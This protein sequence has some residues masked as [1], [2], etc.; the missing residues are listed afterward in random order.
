MNDH[1]L[2]SKEL[3]FISHQARE[4]ILDAIYCT[5]HNKGHDLQGNTAESDVSWF[6]YQL[7]A[8]LQRDPLLQ[9][10]EQL[11]PEERAHWERVA[12]AS[13][14]RLPFLMDRISHRMLTTKEAINTLLHAEKSTRKS[15]KPR[16]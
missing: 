16:R 15:T 14:R 5:L 12:A 2:L 1:T 8:E 6:A 9:A 10:W 7:W 3:D 4:Y 11:P 13:L